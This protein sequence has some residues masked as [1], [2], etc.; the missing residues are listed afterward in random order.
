[1]RVMKKARKPSRKRDPM[2]AGM[3]NSPSG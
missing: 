1:M 3:T 2:T